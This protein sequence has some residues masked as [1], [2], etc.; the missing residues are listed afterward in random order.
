MNRKPIMIDAKLVETLKR[1]ASKHG[2]S[3]ASYMR[4]LINSIVEAENRGL[5][6]PLLLKQAI[7]A[8]RL[9]QTDL[10]PLPLIALDNVNTEILYSEGK[11]IGLLLKNLDISLE[12]ALELFISRTLGIFHEG[13][14]IILVASSERGKKLL[15][16]IKGLVESYNVR[17]EENENILV[18]YK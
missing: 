9:R 11:N 4:S 18:I 14:K 12:D 2:M 1:I 17:I 15:A 8:Y 3:L 13:D 10:I 16:F 6:A 7:I 5:Y